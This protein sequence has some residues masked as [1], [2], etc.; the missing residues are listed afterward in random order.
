[1]QPLRLFAKPAPSLDTTHQRF[2][3]RFV[4]IL[5]VG[6]S[7]TLLMRL[8]FTKTRAWLPLDLSITRSGVLCGRIILGRGF[9]IL[10]I[11]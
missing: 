9:A 6:M 3:C 10:Y 2:V 4:V 11:C 1:M 7:N 8:T 5:Q